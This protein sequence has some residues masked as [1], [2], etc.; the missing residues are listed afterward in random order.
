MDCYANNL[1]SVSSVVFLLLRM[2]VVDDGNLSH[3]VEYELL[4]G[5][6]N[7]LDKLFNVSI[8]NTVNPFDLWSHIQTMN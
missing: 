1:L 3:E 2:D 7:V 5:T 6:T 8:S 4:E